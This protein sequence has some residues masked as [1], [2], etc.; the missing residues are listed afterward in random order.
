MAASAR[1]SGNAM[2]SSWK[3]ANVSYGNIADFFRYFLISF[4]YMN[5]RKTP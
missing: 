3:N 4:N 1:K 2:A 5:H